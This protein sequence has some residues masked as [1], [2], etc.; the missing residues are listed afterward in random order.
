[1]NVMRHIVRGCGELPQCGEHPGTMPLLLLIAIGFSAAGVRG[2]IAMTV[3][4][5][6]VYLWGAYS[7]SV[8]DPP[9]EGAPHGDD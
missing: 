2:G 7:R 4:T 8:E 5:L 1:M 6:P 9:Q 3:A